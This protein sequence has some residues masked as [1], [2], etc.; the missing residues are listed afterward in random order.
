MGTLE[1]IFVSWVVV[2]FCLLFWPCPFLKLTS[3]HLLKI[4][5]SFVIYLEY[6]SQINLIL[7]TY[8]NLDWH[9][10]DSES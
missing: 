8:S 10:H 7:L 2:I 9:R 1:H 6:W 4:V 5:A 3:I